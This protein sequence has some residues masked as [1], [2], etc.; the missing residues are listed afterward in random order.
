MYPAAKIDN[1]FRILSTYSEMQAFL[2]S[3]FMLLTVFLLQKRHILYTRTN[4]ME[5]YRY[6]KGCFWQIP[7]MYLWH[8]Y[9]RWQNLC[10]SCLTPC[11]K[12]LSYGF[13]VYTHTEIWWSTNSMNLQFPPPDKVALKYDNWCQQLIYGVYFSDIDQN[14]HDITSMKFDLN[15]SIKARTL[16]KKD[17]YFYF[18]LLYRVCNA[19]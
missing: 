18:L 10:G 4:S 7:N 11:V 16:Y 17:N 3:H 15:V 1:I 12:L 14:F 13:C 5:I 8:G 2:T 19:A 6:F 9:L